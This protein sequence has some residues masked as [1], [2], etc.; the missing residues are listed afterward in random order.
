MIQLFFF[1]SKGCPPDHLPHLA[2]PSDEGTKAA[3]PIPSPAMQMEKS[4][5]VPFL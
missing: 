1:F 4:D 2:S 5:S 3:R